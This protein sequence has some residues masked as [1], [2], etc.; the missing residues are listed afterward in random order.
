MSG[1]SVKHSSITDSAAAPET[2]N[3]YSGSAVNC[4]R[5]FLL[6]FL[7]AVPPSRHLTLRPI[8]PGH[9]L[10]FFLLPPLTC[11]HSHQSQSLDGISRRSSKGRNPSG[12][13]GQQWQI[14]EVRIFPC[15]NYPIKLWASKA[16]VKPNPGDSGWPYHDGRIPEGRCTFKHPVWPR[17]FYFLRVK[18]EK[19][20]DGKIIHGNLFCLLSL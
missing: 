15:N 6:S 10:T 18:C 1:P 3:R 5:C 14:R 11:E 8:W 17:C 20:K 16:Y 12:V 19:N 9:I 7:I 13:L 2:E 4:E